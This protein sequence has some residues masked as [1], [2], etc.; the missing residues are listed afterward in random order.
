MASMQERVEELAAY[1][2]SRGHACRTD[3]DE[4]TIVTHFEFRQDRALVRVV[5]D[6]DGEDAKIEVYAFARRVAEYWPASAPA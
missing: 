4:S 2:E 1:I 5:V 6:D 3:F